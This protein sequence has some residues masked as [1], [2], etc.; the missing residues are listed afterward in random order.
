[1]LL[2]NSSRARLRR[3]SRSRS[4]AQSALVNAHSRYT[5]VAMSVSGL[6]QSP[7]SIGISQFERV[8]EALR[9]LGTGG[10]EAKDSAALTGER[11]GQQRRVTRQFGGARLELVGDLVA[12]LGG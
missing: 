8:R 4:T 12:C 10:D 9:P 1:M 7:P 3:Y 11:I 5:P 2:H 6:H